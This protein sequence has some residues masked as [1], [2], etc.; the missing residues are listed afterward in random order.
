[1]ADMDENPYKSPQFQ[2]TDQKTPNHP[3]TTTKAAIRGAVIGAAISGGS[4]LLLLPMLLIVG[5]RVP[6]SETALMIPC[7]TFMGGIVGAIVAAIL[8]ALANVFSRR[9]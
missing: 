4:S 8:Q 1:M 7:S 3:T 2:P 6:A 5:A 9:A